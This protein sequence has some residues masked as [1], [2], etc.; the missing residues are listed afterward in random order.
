MTTLRGLSSARYR[1]LSRL[2]KEAYG[3]EA[4][5]W[6]IDTACADLGMLP[7][8]LAYEDWVTASGKVMF[9]VLLPLARAVARGLGSTNST[10]TP[11]PLRALASP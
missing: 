8:H 7:P 3:A 4:Q 1:R 10:S 2:K 9:S 5:D 11:M 6:D